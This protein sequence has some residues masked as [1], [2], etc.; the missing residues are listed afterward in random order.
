MSVRGSYQNAKSFKGLMALS[1][2]V[3]NAGIDP[4]IY[5]LIKLRGSQINGCAFCINMHITDALAIG[6]TQQ[7]INVVSVWRD[8]GLFT[9]RER[10]ALALTEAV[11]L[12]ADHHVSDEVFDEARR[13]FSED[14]VAD[15]MM[16]IVVINAWN[17]ANITFGITLQPE[18]ALA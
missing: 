17:R 3:N 10:A 18:P 14:E 16:A 7:R 8:T 9:E 2:A 4:I 5:E 1:G 11:T 13:L 15:L 12:I 6:E